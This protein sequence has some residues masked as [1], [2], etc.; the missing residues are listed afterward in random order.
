MNFVAPF[1]K[2]PVMTTLFLLALLAAGV[3]AWRSLPVS[4]LPNVDYP[5]VTVNASLPGA[6][7]ETMASSVATPLEKQFSTI[8][9]IDNMTS[10]S[11]LGSTSITIQFSL[12]RDVDAAAQ[13]VQAAI[14]AT[15][16]T[17]PQ[18]IIP[19]SYQKVNP[20][21]SPILFVTLSSTTVPLSQLDEIAQTQLAQQISTVNGV[22]QVQVYGSQKRAVRI[23]M[24]PRRLYQLKLGTSDVAQAVS[25]QS[26]NLPSGTLYGPNRAYTVQASGQLMKAA[27]FGGL[28]VTYRNGAPVRLSDVARVVD[29]VQDDKTAS[30]FAAPDSGLPIRRSISLAIQRQPGTNT[31]EVADAVKAIL[32][33]LTANLPG[34]V[35]IEPLYDRSQ[36]IRESVRDVELTLLLTLFLVVLVVFLFL[37]SPRATAIPAL[38]LPLSICGTFGV[39]QALGYSLD[40]LSLMALTL[41]VGFVVD[42]A[43]VVLENIVRHREMGKDAMTAAFEG[44]QEVAFTV[45]SMT[46]SL[47]AVF[48]PLLFM[49][50]I[51]GRLFREFS[52]T[53]AI[54]ILVSGVVSLTITPM[55]AS[56]FLKNAAPEAAGAEGERVADPKTGETAHGAVGAL[57]RAAPSRAPR[58]AARRGAAA[59]APRARPVRAR[60]RSH[61]PVLRA[62]AAVDDGPPP[63]GASWARCWCS[64]A[65]TS[66]SRR[67]RPASCRAT[68]RASCARRPRPRRA[69]ATRT[70]CATSS[71]RRRSSTR[72]RTSRR[73]SA[74]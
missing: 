56:R 51:V 21:N 41:A 6:S 66:S 47:S 13:D 69:R 28:V 17:L 29:S 12:E 54:S 59:A 42:D 70:W 2:R 74:R 64:S 4:D 68:T 67:S 15:L 61:A 14:S 20:A 26:P 60:V 34:G 37:R 31:V 38:A 45:L 44:S 9:G 72:I 53:I 36:T 52:V 35:M 25:A 24:D 39:M 10:T 65:P 23:R 63:G 5:T 33:K 27:D 7:P 55:L 40:N 57:D 50:G 73:S 19:P 46:L 43:I 30:W 11:Q 48:L 58:L 32:P 8:A 3:F 62:H 71:K 18:G 16:R 1:I 49:G 22:A